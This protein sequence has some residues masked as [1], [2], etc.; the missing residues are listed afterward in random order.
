VLLDGYSEGLLASAVTLETGVGGPACPWIIRVQPHQRIN[1]TLL[2][3][4]LAS[5]LSL[6]D[7]TPPGQPLAVTEKERSCLRFTTT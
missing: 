1:I 4:S 3:F 5:A 2:D 7:D 6:T